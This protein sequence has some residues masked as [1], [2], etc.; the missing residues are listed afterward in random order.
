MKNILRNKKLLIILL[1]LLIIIIGIVVFWITRK[2]SSNIV[3]SDP[4]ELTLVNI[5]DLN[6]NFNDTYYSEFTLIDGMYS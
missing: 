6:Y 5:D 1:V 3:S 4:Y 2:D